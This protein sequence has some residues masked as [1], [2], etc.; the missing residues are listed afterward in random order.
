M[1]AFASRCCVRFTR[2]SCTSMSKI[3]PRSLFHNIIS[4][5]SVTFLLAD[6]LPIAAVIIWIGDF[7][8]MPWFF[9]RF[10]APERI[11]QYFA[12]QVVLV[13]PTEAIAQLEM[14]W[15]D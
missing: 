15:C 8:G 3:P 10:P 7:P 1:R 14:I 11:Q 4:C 13:W 2:L 5:F 6:W 9:A 12:L